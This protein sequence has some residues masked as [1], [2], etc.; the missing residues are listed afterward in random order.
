MNRN[1]LYAEQQTEFIVGLRKLE[2]RKTKKPIISSL[3]ALLTKSTLSSAAKA[4]LIHDVGS[5]PVTSI[6]CIEFCDNDELLGCSFRSEGKR[7]R[8]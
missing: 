3:S 6:R 5:A 7:A 1:T 2:L 8:D 4:V